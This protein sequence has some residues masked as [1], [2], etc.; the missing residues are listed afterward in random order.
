[1]TA[2]NAAP[3]ANASKPYLRFNAQEGSTAFEVVTFNSTEDM[4]SYKV[5]FVG[6]TRRIVAVEDLSTVPTST[7]LAMFNTVRKRNGEEPL[8]RFRDRATAESRTFDILNALATP[9][10][11]TGAVKA[12]SDKKQADETKAADKAAK[13]AE[14]EAAKAKREQEREAKKAEKE[15]AKAAAKANKAPGVID[16]IREHVT[17][18]T[19]FGATI[20]EIMGALTKAFP[21]RDADGMKTTV[22]IQVSRLQKDENVGAI[23]SAV[24]EGRGRVYA[25]VANPDQIPGERPAPKVKAAKP[26]AAQKAVQAETVKSVTKAAAKNAT[27]AKSAKEKAREN[28]KTTATPV[29]S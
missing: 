9:Y 6:T 15:A 8:A 28:I 19:P 4:R 2:P 13:A 16:V 22:R 23:S 27:P 14:K 24:I 12:M 11:P 10:T 17:R 3:A 20:D 25:N 1:M 5:A 18:R 26:T 21:D 7:L 29:G